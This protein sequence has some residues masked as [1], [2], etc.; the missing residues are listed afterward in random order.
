[1]SYSWMLEKCIRYVCI[2]Q[3]LQHGTQRMASVENQ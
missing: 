2:E 1:M 3:T